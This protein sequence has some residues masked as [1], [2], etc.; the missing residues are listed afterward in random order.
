MPDVETR[1]VPHQNTAVVRRRCAPDAISAAM[2]EGFSTVLAA[3][4]RAG[5]TPGAV[6]A[7][8]FS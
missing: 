4:G 6:F 8:C 7:R 1:H 2:G 3:L 5:A